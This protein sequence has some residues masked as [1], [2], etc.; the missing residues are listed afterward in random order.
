MFKHREFWILVK[1]ATPQKSH[2]HK[3]HKTCGYQNGHNQKATAPL[4]KI[5]T[6]QDYYQNSHTILVKT[7]TH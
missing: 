4:V 3:G 2:T 6:Y 7:A 1:T 5:A